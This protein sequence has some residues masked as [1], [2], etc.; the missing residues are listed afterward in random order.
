M[1]K[2]VNLHLYHAITFFFFF[3]GYNQYGINVNPNGE[4][5]D[6]ISTKKE[7]K[8]IPHCDVNPLV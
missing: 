8:C 4:Y 2:L 6:L 5:L 1:T 7:E 3:I